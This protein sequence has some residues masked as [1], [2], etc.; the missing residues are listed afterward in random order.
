M[1]FLVYFFFFWVSVNI[2]AVFCHCLCFVTTV[3]CTCCSSEPWKRN[4][5]SLVKWTLITSSWGDC[6]IK[7]ILYSFLFARNLGLYILLVNTKCEMW[8]LRFFFFFTENSFFFLVSLNTTSVTQN[9]RKAARQITSE[10]KEVLHHKQLP[11]WVSMWDLDCS[12]NN[13]KF[14]Y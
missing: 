6:F 14:I 3:A 13:S 11:P 10:W 5:K 9:N 2:Y 7:E 8:L 12:C 1:K 4:L